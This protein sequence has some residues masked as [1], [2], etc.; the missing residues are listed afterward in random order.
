MKYLDGTVICL[1][2]YHGRLPLPEDVH[3]LAEGVAYAKK[4]LDEIP[5]GELEYIMDSDGLDE[6]NC[7][8]V[9]EP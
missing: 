8:L 6:E 1:A 4:H 7:C 2:S 3:T 9:E 5:L